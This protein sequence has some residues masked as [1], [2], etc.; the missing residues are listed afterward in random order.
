MPTGDASRRGVHQHAYGGGQSAAHLECFALGLTDIKILSTPSLVVVDNQF[1][2]LLVGDLVTTR[3][4]Q[5]VDVPMAPV[6]N[7]ARRKRKPIDQT[8][9]AYRDA[10]I[11]VERLYRWLLDVIR[12]E[13]DQGAACRRFIGSRFPSQPGLR[14]RSHRQPQ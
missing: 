1:A 9:P 7:K 8:G 4:A 2:F 14:R 6:V 3:T 12:D 13:L 11:F 5:S 10:L